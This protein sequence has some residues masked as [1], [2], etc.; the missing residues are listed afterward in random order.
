MWKKCSRTA[1]KKWD[2]VNVLK[3]P[4]GFTREEDDNVDAAAFSKDDLTWNGAGALTI[5]S[6][7]GNGMTSKDDLVITGGSYTVTS[8]GHGLEGKES[9]RIA[10]GT[11]SI[12]SGKDGIHAEDKDDESLGF[13][14][15]AGGTFQITADGDIMDAATIL[16]VDGGTVQ[17]SA[18][19]GSSLADN[20][21]RSEFDF[22]PE[23]NETEEDTD[24]ASTK[25]LKAGQRLLIRGGTFELDA[26]D[27]TLHSNGSIGIQDGIFTLSSGD[28]GVH[29]D[30]SVEITGGVMDIV[31]SYE[32]IEGRTILVEAGIITLTASDDGLN[33]ADGENS[34]FGPMGEG[35]AD[36]WIRIQGG[37]IHITA[38][39]DGID[40]NGDLYVSGGEIRVSGPTN[41]GNG[42]LDYAG[43]AEITGGTAVLA[44]HSGMEMNFGDTSSQ[45]V[46]LVSTDTV[47]EAGSTISVMDEEGTVLLSFEPDKTYNSVLVSSPEMVTGKTYTIAAREET[48]EVELT[49]IVYGSESGM[50]G[51]GFGGRG[52]GRGDGGG[53]FSEGMEPPDGESMPEG[54][55]PPDG[56]GMPERMS[57]P[58][59][60]GVPDASAPTDG[61]NIA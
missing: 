11:F 58:D 17:A 20:S 22:G 12:A 23:N 18:G 19:G 42:C 52:F 9:V 30:E 46:I 40:S 13:L 60:E 35:S 14:Y 7:D 51:G 29:A 15:I 10:D 3:S 4:G 49:E 6:Q 33:A 59:G 44:G 24:T 26:L 53:R 38:E 56:E 21:G 47:Q 25:G 8:T 5:V 36:D 39:G 54:M 55:E 61:G 1:I 57:P 45:G 41:G 16:Q 43:T 27:D 31:T 32:G 28:D 2:T 50:M 34:G 37:V 48:L